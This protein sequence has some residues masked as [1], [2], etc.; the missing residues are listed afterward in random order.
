VRADLA[1]FDAGAP[2]DLVFSNAALHWLPE[3]PAL[4]AA[5]AGRVAAGGQLAVQM[6][7][8]HAEPSHALI[9]EVAREPEHAAAL[10]GW[11]KPTHVLWPAAYARVLHALGFA[12]PHVRVQAY[13]HVLP[14]PEAVVDWVRGTTL[15]AYEQRLP[16]PA[17]E[18]FVARY[19]DR[20]LEELPA[21]RP[22][23]YVF[24]RLLLWGRKP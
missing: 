10:G 7:C 15:T 19:R 14:G 16:A 24:H 6:P 20:L 23:L 9:E 17:F 13:C 5:L 22:F 18:R 8:N 4:F 3:H 21:E 11:V 1:G 12:D 2:Y